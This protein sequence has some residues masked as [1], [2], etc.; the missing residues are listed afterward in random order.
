MAAWDVDKGF[1]NSTGPDVNPDLDTERKT[2]S[3]SVERLTNILDGGAENTQIR[4]KVNAVLQSDPE[5]SR[6]NQYFHS[7]NERY[8]GAV[9]RSLYLS[10]KMDEMGW[11]ADGPEQ[12][13]CYRALGDDLAFSVHNVFMKSIL[14]LGTDKQ[15]A[16]WIPLAEK[17]Y[18]AGTYA[19][20]ELGHGTYLRGLETTATFDVTTQEFILNTPKISAMKWWPGDLGRTATHAV[21]FAQLYIKGKCYGI[22][23]FVMQIRSLQDHSPA[24]G[25]TVG[26][27]GPKMN[28]AQTDNG[29]L[30]LRNVRIP[31]ESMLSRFSQI[32]PDG[33]YIKQGSEKINY[34]TMVVVRVYLIRTEILTIL[35]K[36]CTIAV[37]YSVVRRQSELKPGGPESKILDY[38]TQQQKL[39]P[40]VA[41]AYAFHFL[42]D[43]L[44][45]VFDRGYAETK[46]GKFD[47]LP[48]LHALASGM[49]VIASDFSSAGV[50]VC[51]RACGG[52]GYSLLSG[53]PSLFTK[54]V[55]S[56]TYEGENTVLLLQTAR[57]LVKCLG[58]VKVGQPLPSSV[59]YLSSTSSGK[60][61]AQEKRD[62]LNP[63]VYTAAYKQRAFRMVR[64]A[65]IK[66]HSLIQSGT[67]QHEA[68]NLCSVQLA[69][70]AM[71]HSHYIV[72]QNFV[73]AL[74]KF[75]KEFHIQRVLKHLCDL[76]ALHGI[77]SNMGDFLKTGHLSGKQSDMVTESY[78]D[79]L[80][81]VRPDAVPLVDAFDFSD[82]NL[83]SAI[84]CYDGHAYERLFEW[85][86][87]SPTNNQ[88][89]QTF[90]KYLKPLFRNAL[91][92]L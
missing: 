88:D 3:F 72:V 76:F 33:Q 45:E 47:L 40:Q 62:F 20:T 44:Q 11:T 46:E 22:H 15:I 50:E 71:A 32:L 25:V 41:T 10:K 48:E 82:A 57:F 21:V 18:I 6:E 85:A 59:A 38:Q 61:G 7:Q 16:K 91:S 26:D 28:F 77:V 39:L 29:Y 92:K 69:R 13:Y 8:E 75:E 35:M 4:R 27:I 31:K 1:Q 30:M 70:S 54:V 2:A 9:R 60:C 43:Y 66:I 55:A 5:F 74:E 19:Q 42:C 89:N 63:D 80:A 24:P 84:G 34:L 17:H 58:A 49:K 65:A 12:K 79:L 87:K 37:R 86:K 78:L 73:N 36:A 83:N 68:W 67:P 53:L 56:C 14:G 64:N 81:L 52:H 23:P 90:E 51:R